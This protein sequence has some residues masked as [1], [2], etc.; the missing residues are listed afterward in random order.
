MYRVAVGMDVIIVAKKLNCYCAMAK[1]PSTH[2]FVFRPVI[3]FLCPLS[4]LGPSRLLALGE[5]S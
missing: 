2:V 5:I 1:G 3:S 4:A